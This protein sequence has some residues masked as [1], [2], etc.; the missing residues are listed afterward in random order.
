M[1]SKFMAPVNILNCINNIQYIQCLFFLMLTCLPATTL[2][3]VLFSSVNKV[4]KCLTKIHVKKMN[5]LK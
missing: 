1:I 3:M 4:T 2:S 5:E